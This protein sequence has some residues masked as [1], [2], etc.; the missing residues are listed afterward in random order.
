MRQVYAHQAILDGTPGLTLPVPH[1]VTRDGTRL[2]V[3]FATEP[4]RVD[5]IRDRIDAALAGHG[6]VESGCT[7]L[8][9]AERHQARSLLRECRTPLADSPA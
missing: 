5:E 6:L 3:L 9:P 2:R 8:D 7:R 4:D 1:L